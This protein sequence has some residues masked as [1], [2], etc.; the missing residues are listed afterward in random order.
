MASPLDLS[1]VWKMVDKAS[2]ELAKLRGNVDKTVKDVEKGGNK[3][4]VAM[5]FGVGAALGIAALVTGFAALVKSVANTGDEFAKMSSKTMMSV[6]SLSA[7][8]YAAELSDVTN[9]QLETGIVKLN[10]AMSEAAQ[11]TKLYSEA[12]DDLGVSVVDADGKLR[13]TEEVFF[14][15]ADAIATMSNNADK[16]DLVKA[17]F[18]KAG[19]ELLPLLNEGKE[20][21][22]ALR[23]EAERMGKV[24]STDTAKASEELN[25][26]LTRLT[27]VGRGFAIQIASPIIRG[28]ADITEEMRKASKE[29]GFL[30]TTMV[31]LAGVWNTVRWGSADLAKISVA[32]L[33]EKTERQKELMQEIAEL[34]KTAGGLFFQDA[35]KLEKANKELAEVTERMGVLQEVIKGNEIIAARQKA[36]QDQLKDAERLAK[37]SEEQEKLNAKKEDFLKALQKELDMMGAASYEQR[38]Y[39][40]EAFAATIVN[41]KERLA[42]LQSAAAIANKITVLE[43]AIAAAKEW[44]AVAEEYIAKE[45]AANAAIESSIKSL[46]EQTEQLQLENSLYGKTNAEREVAIAQHNLEKL[47]YDAKTTAAQNFLGTLQKELEL[48]EDQS[49]ITSIMS[50]TNLQKT[51]DLYKDLELI[52]RAYFDGLKDADGN[53]IY[54]MSDAEYAQAT[55][56]LTGIVDAN[57]K[58]TDEVT[59]FWR[60]AAE[61]MQQSMSG[62]F[63]DIMQGNLSNLG[64]SFK[65]TI[66]K[67]VA[68]M[69]AAKA[70]TALFGSDFGKGGSIGGLVGSFLG[71]LPARESGGPVTAGQ[72]YVVGERRPEIFVPNTNGTIIPNTNQ[73]SQQNAVNASF[74]ITAMDTQDVL[75]AM[76]KIKRPL[77]EM[78]NGTNRAYN[79]GR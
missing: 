14:D 12:F 68:D 61:S 77:A 6:E 47:G 57:K 59:E 54:Q 38:I 71:M 37:E 70:A 19:T 33:N 23:E 66:D 7:L 46:R 20:G 1:M 44:N 3:M 11:D 72:A 5:K 8:S 60:S 15:V 13:N 49:R 51:K 43:A 64:Q 67:M 62:F 18:G 16:V 79:L 36:L 17:I 22:A 65:R 2:P 69:L 24:M 41:E 34:E 21:L 40:I 31:G 55:E 26:N 32:E 10:E 75:R 53:T 30:H 50:G 29:G 27:A 9:Q 76:D 78:M 74:H 35:S 45:D 52:D 4:G 42:F 28:L 56:Q 39:A 73:L 58:A 25:D 48:R 63:F